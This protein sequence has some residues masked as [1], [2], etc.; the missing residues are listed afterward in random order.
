MGGGDKTLALGRGSDTYEYANDKGEIKEGLWGSGSTKKYDGFKRGGKIRSHKEWKSRNG[1]TPTGVYKYSD[2][3]ISSRT[4]TFGTE[5]RILLDP[6]AG[7]AAKTKGRS[8]IMV[9]A[10]EPS[11]DG[12]RN[13]LRPTQG[14]V[15]LS[16]DDMKAIN[17]LIEAYKD[18]KRQYT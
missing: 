1:D 17:G 16:A 10:G 2:G 13:G 11:K 12:S 18:D 5:K 7:N 15:R 9:H 8:G 3:G 14:C 4:K 6:V